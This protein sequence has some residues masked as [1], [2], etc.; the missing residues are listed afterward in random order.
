MLQT[1]NNNIVKIY[2]FIIF[3]IYSPY[4]DLVALKICITSA[5]LIKMS[6]L[7]AADRLTIGSVVGIKS[8]S[9]V[10]PQIA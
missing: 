2:F 6:I 3:L 9:A 8:G 10:D 5:S 1:Q 7:N 4:L